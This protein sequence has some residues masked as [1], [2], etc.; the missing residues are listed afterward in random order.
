MTRRSFIL[1]FLTFLGAS[2]LHLR[3]LVDPDLW[4][5]LLAGKWFWEHGTAPLTEFYIWGAASDLPTVFSAWGF[6][7]LLYKVW[8]IFGYMGISMACA[9]LWGIWFSVGLL[10]VSSPSPSRLTAQSIYPSL[11]A[12]LLSLSFLFLATGPRSFA[13]AEV[14]LYVCWST[15]IY[16][17]SRFRVSKNTS[18]LF[19]LPACSFF[20]AWTHTTCLFISLLLAVEGV[21]DYLREHSGQ[22]FRRWLRSYGGAFFSA[23]LLALL[24]PLTN[25]N[26]MEKVY[27]MIDGFSGAVYSLMHPVT[28]PLLSSDGRWPTLNIEYIGI[29]QSPNERMGFFILLALAPLAWFVDQRNRLRNAVFFTLF[30]TMTF[31]ASRASG[32][33]AMALA[34]PLYLLILSATQHLLSKNK[35]Y[36][37]L[38]LSLS[39]TLIFS[40]FIN[41]PQLLW[42]EISN[43][44]FPITEQQLKIHY[45]HGGK[46]LNSFALG[47]G[48]AWALSPQW[49]VV[50]DGHFTKNYFTAFNFYDQIIQMTPG[51][52]K[53]LDDNH[54][55]AAVL[56]SVA[57][58]FGYIP[59]LS[60]ELLNHP[61]WSVAGLEN[62]G[63]LVFVRLKEHEVKN[64]HQDKTLFWSQVLRTAAAIAPSTHGEWRTMTENTIHSAQQELEALESHKQTTQP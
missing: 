7:A 31:G 58:R 27:H 34:A 9:L 52:E 44:G 28:Q 61:H 53:T 62:N 56:L 41:T 8:S 24:L 42:M 16:A 30:A 21:A 29:L 50:M 25:P 59:K 35:A 40:K 63:A 6:G 18:W 45:P 19:V 43:S 26:G 60:Y 15:S 32:I 57:P 49:K 13:R 22:P 33:F 11:V 10:S 39:F 17:L 51:W 64:L 55:N 36:C 38:L 1:F 46:V 54:V 4:F 23:F 48:L 3:P 20:L 14:L 2:L 12:A 47:S 37:L 5:N